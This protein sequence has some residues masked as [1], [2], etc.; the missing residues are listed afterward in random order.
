MKIKR[1]KKARIQFGTR[2]IIGSFQYTTL[3]TLTFFFYFFLKIHYGT[4]TQNLSLKM[5]NVPQ[6]IKIKKELVI[7][8]V[9][10]GT[11]IVF[12]TFIFLHLAPL[13]LRTYNTPNMHNTNMES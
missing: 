10:W 4:M 5:Q 8:N 7:Q 6:T 9:P 1:L 3:H 11:R 2:C 12:S 13:F